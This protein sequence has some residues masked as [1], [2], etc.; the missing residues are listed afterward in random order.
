MMGIMKWLFVPLTAALFAMGAQNPQ[1][2]EIHSVYIL[3]MSGSLDQF[4][5]VRLN[6]SNLFLVVTDPK[7]ADAVF[8]E[9]I[10]VNFEDALKELYASDTKDAKE[11]KDDDYS[12]PTMKPLSNGKGSV[13]LVDRK[14]KNVV[15]SVYDR[16]KSNRADDVNQLAQKIVKKLEKDIKGK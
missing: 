4:L 16:P 8:T 15:W 9:R 13:F 7:K 12:R 2:A 11:K 10:G 6:A 1:L 14:T 3:P 5:A